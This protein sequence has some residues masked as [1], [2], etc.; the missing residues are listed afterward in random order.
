MDEKKY[1][2]DVIKCSRGTKRVEAYHTNL[3]VTF[4]GW[5]MGLAMLT[6]LI[7]VRGGWVLRRRTY[8]QEGLV[9][10]AVELRLQLRIW[11]SRTPSGATTNL[12]KAS[13]CS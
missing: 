7:V 4:G 9:D 11:R 6:V 3:Q 1:G 12:D 2:M 5:I 10:S 8:S 13:R